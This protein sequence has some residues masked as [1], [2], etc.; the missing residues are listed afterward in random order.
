MLRKIP[1]KKH[2]LG[3]FTFLMAIVAFGQHDTKDAT[4]YKEVFE[5]GFEA[6]LSGLFIRNTEEGITDYATELHLTYW[7]TH[8]WAFGLG[9]TMIFEEESRIGHELAGLISH[10]PYTFLTVNIGPSFSLPNAHKDTEVS[11]YIETEWAFHIGA[12]HV[13]PTLG[14]LIGN[15]FRYFGGLHISYEF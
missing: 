4:E 9:Y 10:K 8:K 6:V 3:V 13:G 15:D 14:A 12:F 5:P 1:N 2:I 7:T 11:G